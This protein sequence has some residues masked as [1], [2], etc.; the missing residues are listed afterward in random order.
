VLKRRSTLD[1]LKSLLADPG[2]GWARKMNGAD[3]MTV[4]LH[5]QRQY[6]IPAEVPSH[7]YRL[8]FCRTHFRA[9]GPY[10]DH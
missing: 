1:R 7:F 9:A 8:E 6:R 3:P 10:R 4:Y 2:I 5:A